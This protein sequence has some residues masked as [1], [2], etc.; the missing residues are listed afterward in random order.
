MCLGYD[1]PD[2][3]RSDLKTPFSADRKQGHLQISISISRRRASKPNLLS[4]QIPPQCNV[5]KRRRRDP[6]RD[7]ARNRSTLYP[8]APL[9]YLSDNDCNTLPR[10]RTFGS[11]ARIIAVPVTRGYFRFRNALVFYLCARPVFTVIHLESQFPC[12]VQ[13]LYSRSLFLR[14]MANNSWVDSERVSALRTE[15]ADLLRNSAIYSDELVDALISRVVKCLH[16][17]RTPHF[18]IG[19]DIEDSQSD[20]SRKSSLCSPI[21]V[22]EAPPTP[23]EEE[24]P[25]NPLDVY[26]TDAAKLSDDAILELLLSKDIKHRDLEKKLGHN[27]RAVGVRRRYRAV[28]VRRRYVEELTR[29]TLEDM[30]FKGYNYEIVDGACCENVIGF[31]PVPTG[32]VGPLLLNGESIHVPMAT[33][34]GTLLASTNRGCRVIMD[35]GGVE[36]HVERDEMT[37]AP[38]VEF[39]TVKE[40]VNFAEFVRDRSGKNFKTFKEKFESTTSFG[41]LLRIEPER[42]DT[43]VLLRFSASTGDAMGMNMVSKGAD[44][45]LKYFKTLFPSMDVLT[46]SGNYCADKKATMINWIKGRGKSVVASCT[47]PERV[48]TNVLKTTVDRMA[49]V[50]K[51]KCLTGSSMAGTVGGWNCHAANA[52][53]AIFVATGQDA[54]QVVSSSMCFTS[55]EKTDRGD[56]RV[57]CDMKCME[58]GTVGGG[59][60]LPSQKAA[61]AMMKCAGGDQKDPGKNARQLAQ[62]ICAT[63]LAGEISLLAAQCTHTLV[64]S[65]MTY[66]RSKYNLPAAATE[67]ESRKEEKE[68]E[69]YSTTLRVQA[70]K[71]SGRKGGMEIRCDH[72]L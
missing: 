55:W 16:G 19:D 70:V 27:E 61:L 7:F 43:K 49:K 8:C 46:V 33:T 67:K 5:K 2:L 48:V 58:V 3:C 62:V 1:K 57:S 59:T 23:A 22:I 17:S 37:R 20:D 34:E 36:T 30:P 14:T 26:N 18:S 10:L 15:F 4:K 64:S 39:K 28:G 53:A 24:S 71:T 38:M 68:E 21:P 54:A 56:L 44:E 25:Q 32:V 35:S 51:E 40:A 65:H 12:M 60:F 13:P 50:G 29:S 31:T 52:V 66:N 11:K 45:V 63:V 69:L 6:T 9:P 72:I 47:I 41:K 42:I